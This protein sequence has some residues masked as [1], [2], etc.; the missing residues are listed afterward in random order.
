MILPSIILLIILILLSILMVVSFIGAAAYLLGF[1][2][3]KYYG[4]RFILYFLISV[5]LIRLIDFFV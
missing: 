5:V 2:K 1:N 4:N 3:I